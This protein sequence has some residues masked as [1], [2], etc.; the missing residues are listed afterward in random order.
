M[1]GGA[2]LSAMAEMR[3][4]AR[5]REGEE[6]GSARKLAA[7]TLKRSAAWEE[8]RCGRNGEADLRRPEEEDDGEGVTA[9]LPASLGTVRG[10]SG[11]RRFF[12]TAQGRDATAV[13]AVVVSGVDGSARLRARKR[14]RGGGESRE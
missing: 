10:R 8:V 6:R 5:E 3:P 13:G 1:R 11:S 7:I 12:W 2:E 14:V 4:G 9:G